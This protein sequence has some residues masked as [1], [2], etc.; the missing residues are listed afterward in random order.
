MASKRELNRARL[1]RLERETGHGIRQGIRDALASFR[2]GAGTR[3][4][5]ARGSGVSSLESLREAQFSREKE[6]MR[7]DLRKYVSK[8]RKRK[9]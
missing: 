1:R 5:G 7:K 8:L 3:M 2:V 6:A 4:T 9:K